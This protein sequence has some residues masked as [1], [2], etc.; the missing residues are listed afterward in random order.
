MVYFSLNYLKSN[1]YGFRKNLSELYEIIEK[2]IEANLLTSNYISSVLVDVSKSFLIFLKSRSLL[3]K[4]YTTISNSTKLD[5]E[6]LKSLIPVF[7]F[8]EHLEILGYAIKTE[9]KILNLALYVDASIENFNIKESSVKLYEC[10]EELKRLKVVTSYQKLP[11][12]LLTWLSHLIRSLSNKFSLY[13][14]ETINLHSNSNC[15]L[16]EFLNPLTEY[17]SNGTKLCI[18]Y[19]VSDSIPF[20]KHGYECAQKGSSYVKPDGL[21]SYPIILNCP[22]ETRT[23]S[24]E[25]FHIVN[26]VSLIGDYQKKK[27]KKKIKKIDLKLNYSWFFLKK[28]NKKLNNDSS[29][30]TNGSNQNTKIISNENTFGSNHQNEN[31]ED[32]IENFHL[33]GN[34]NFDD[35]EERNSNSS[36]YYGKSDFDFK[37]DVIKFLDE[38]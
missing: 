9:A 34:E 12:K 6:K 37:E 10:N 22:P 3:V 11:Y 18:F 2:D 17:C 19:K 21:A 16:Q 31:L 5:T 28:G 30:S 20:W 7:Q 26:L 27:N 23:N 35:D 33:S 24:L 15:L 8:D 29:I 1:A 4:L 14:F 25:N 38:E 36:N 13:F 32:D